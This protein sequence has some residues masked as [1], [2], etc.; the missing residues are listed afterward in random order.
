MLVSLGGI[1]TRLALQR[2]PVVPRVRYVIAGLPTP[3]RA[4]MIALER[5]GLSHLDCLASCDAVVTKPG[6]G[7]VAEAGCHNTPTLFVARGI[8]PEEPYLVHWLGQNGT[9]REIARETLWAGDLADDLDALWAQ[10]RKLPPVA[11]GNDEAA[12]LIAEML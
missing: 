4:D 10:P 5:T 2:W 12:R 3:P 9:A 11:S 8:W 6:Y 7:T 1:D